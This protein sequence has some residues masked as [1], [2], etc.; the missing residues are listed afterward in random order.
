MPLATSVA[1]IYNKAVLPMIYNLLF[2]CYSKAMEL[3]TGTFP[4]SVDYPIA[5]RTDR[6]GRLYH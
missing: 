5:Y 1:Y 4:P 3:N 6:Q 2:I